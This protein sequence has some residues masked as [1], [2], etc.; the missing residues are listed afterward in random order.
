M[1][2]AYVRVP[3]PGRRRVRAPYTPRKP[4]WP[5]P[6]LSLRWCDRWGCALPSARGGSRGRTPGPSSGVLP[7]AAAAPG[8]TC[9]SVAPVQDWYRQVISNA[10]TG[11]RWYPGPVLARGKAER[12]RGVRQMLDTYGQAGRAKRHRWRCEVSADVA[13]STRVRCCSC[14]RTGA[15]LCL[16]MYLQALFS[17][18][19][20][21]LPRGCLPRPLLNGAR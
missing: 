10:A 16:R 4:G 14:A 20:A 6:R 3:Y 12:P 21:G 13:A 15:E 1:R 9:S 8:E 11:Y 7:H 5:S 2:P 17:A 19:S 18:A